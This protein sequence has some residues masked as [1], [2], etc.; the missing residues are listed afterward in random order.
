MSRSL[1]QLTLAALL[2]SALAA[3][4]D[5]NTLLMAEIPEPALSA[6]A[7]QNTFLSEI[8]NATARY[9]RVEVALEAGYAPVSP[10]VSSPLGGMGY[11]YR[12]DA[13]VDGVVD[14]SRPE[15][16]LYEPTKNGR[17]GLVGVEFVVP[18]S[19]WTDPSPPRLGDQEFG[20]DPFGNHALH[21]WVWRHNPSGMYADFNPRVSCEQAP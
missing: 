1:S 21:V 20:M 16:L 5:Q 15:M 6:V 19:L 2:A 13:L 4:G 7:Q 17:L 10:C 18:P 12:N 9:H 8:R 14:P 3:C 11:H